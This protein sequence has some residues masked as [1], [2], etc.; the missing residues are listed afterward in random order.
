MPVEGST[1]YRRCPEY[2]RRVISKGGLRSEVGGV[3]FGLGLYSVYFRLSA[4]SPVAVISSERLSLSFSFRYI[5]INRFS[6]AVSSIFCPFLN[7][8]S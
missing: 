5:S 7:I 6:A 1:V 4:S 8:T 2:R 3:Y